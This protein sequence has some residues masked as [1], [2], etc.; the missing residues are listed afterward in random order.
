MPL[1]PH[2]L[3]GGMA[4]HAD[5]IRRTAIELID[6]VAGSPRCEFLSRVAEAFPSTIFLHIL[7]VPLRN[8]R[9]F[10]DLAKT[11]MGAS[12]AAYRAAA[13]ARISEIV[14]ETVTERMAEPRKDLISAL[15]GLDFG[16]RKLSRA[17]LV[18]YA[19][20]LFVGGLDTVVNGLSF[21]IRYL[22]LHP[23]LQS[24]LRADPGKIPSAV[25]ELLRLHAVATPMR[26][27]TR[28]LTL[29]GVHIRKGEQLVLLVAAINYDPKAFANAG[30]F[31][32]HRP[33]A[34]VTFNMGPHRCIGASLGR[35]ELKI[36]LE[37]W[38]QRIPAFRLDPR[39]PPTFGG[40]FSITVKSLPLLLS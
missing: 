9:E 5:L 40:G 25:E 15:A 19:A 37:E 8:L 16:G 20:I 2:F 18:D 27:A 26:T 28:D 13:D 11:F 29:H 32:P 38:L 24:E 33:E 14:G 39:D 4:R 21:S 34:H 10:R 12:A 6:A 35:L 3:P 17:E 23:E 7:G 22:A 36:F 31:C 30:A 1:N